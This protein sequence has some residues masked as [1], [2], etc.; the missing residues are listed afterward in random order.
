MAKALRDRL[1]ALALICISLL[2]IRAATAFRGDGDVFPVAMASLLILCCLLKLVR[3]GVEP[4]DAP[5]TVPV[6]WRR[7][8]LLGVL[9]MAML[10]LA[11]PL[12]MYLVI[13]AFMLAALTLLAGLGF[14]KATVIALVFTGAII[15]VFDWLLGV[16][17]PAGLLGGILG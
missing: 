3:P 11:E 2:A 8:L 14:G 7:F 9:S 1:L 10:L 5:D 13:P 15:I 17:T 16:P 12:G 6:I 4:N